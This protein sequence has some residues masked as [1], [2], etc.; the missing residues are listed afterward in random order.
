MAAYRRHPIFARYYVRVVPAMD[1]GGVAEHRRALLAGTRGRVIEVGAG[2]GMNF[3]HYPEGVDEVFAV[4]PEPRLR[5][6]AAAAARTAPVPVTVA[7]G[8]AEDLPAGDQSFDAAVVCLMLCSVDDRDAALSELFRV[9]KPGGRLHV[10]EH[11]R[12]ASP[13]LTRV[14]RVLDATI[15]PALN[16]NCH[17]AADTRDAIGRAGFVKTDFRDVMWPESR[18]PM[19]FSVHILGTATRP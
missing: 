14:Q 11:V 17:L 6:L 8:V 7:G 2:P 16:G 10:F 3:A 18:I 15:W 4:E 13:G 5:A 19:P 9:L 1:R 12:A